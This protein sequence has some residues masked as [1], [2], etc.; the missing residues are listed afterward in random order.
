MALGQAERF[1][2][3]DEQVLEKT[4]VFEK[5]PLKNLEYHQ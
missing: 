1:G 5:D 4:I 3:R 2:V